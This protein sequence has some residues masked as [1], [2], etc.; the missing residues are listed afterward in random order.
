MHDRIKFYLP[1]RYF[2]SGR[3]I[4][5]NAMSRDVCV[6]ILQDV[7]GSPNGNPISSWGCI[8]TSHPEGF[9]ILCRADQFGMF[10]IERNERGRCINGIRDLRP[11]RVPEPDPVQ[12]LASATDLSREDVCCVLDALKRD[13]KLK[14]NLKISH[15]V[16]DVSGNM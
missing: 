10:I 15:G 1:H 5:N 2:E 11:K 7:F 3:G 14:I 6:E 16:T 8:M 4:S 12:E 9:S 13:F